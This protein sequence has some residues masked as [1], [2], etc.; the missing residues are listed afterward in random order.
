MLGTEGQFEGVVA[1]D[2]SLLQINQFPAELS[3]SQRGLAMVVE[4]NGDLIGVSRGPNLKP[5]AEGRP[6]A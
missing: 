2:L 6:R 3:I 5:G 4:P 1:T